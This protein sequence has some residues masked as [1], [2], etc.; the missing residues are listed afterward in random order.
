MNPST[1]I[2]FQDPPSF[3]SSLLPGVFILWVGVAAGT[4]TLSA[5]YSGARTP[6]TALIQSQDSETF[7]LLTSEHDIGFE[8]NW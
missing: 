6:A 4:G 3:F 7:D 1:P 5:R 2:W 8:Q